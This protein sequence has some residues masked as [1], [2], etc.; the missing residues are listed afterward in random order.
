MPISGP[1]EGWYTRA[2]AIREELGDRGGLAFSFGQ[3]GRLA[4]QRGNLRQ[5]LEWMVRCVKLFEDFPHPSTGPAPGHL[6]RLA[7]QLG[8]EALEACW[9]QVTGQPLSTPVR[10]FVITHP[11]GSGGASEG[12]AGE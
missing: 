9:M 10:V 5:A 6:A 7:H 1:A 2:L 4:E 12:E 8:M 11:P 3:L